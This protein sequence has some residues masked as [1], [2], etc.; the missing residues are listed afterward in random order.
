MDFGLKSY[1]HSW[2]SGSATEYMLKK[3]EHTWILDE[4]EDNSDIE[5]I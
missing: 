5:R 3:S 1:V 2:Q 4:G